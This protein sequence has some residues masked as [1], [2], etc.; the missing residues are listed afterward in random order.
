[1]LLF[2]GELGAAASLIQQLQPAIEATG[3]KRVPYSA[4]GLSAFAGRQAEAATQIDA[5]TTDVVLRGEGVGITI[6]EWASALLNNGIGNYEEAA[7]AAQSATEY[8]GEMITPPWPAVELIEAAVRCGRGDVAAEALR[9]LAEITTASGTDW[10]LGIEA[11]SRALLSDG[12]AAERWYR[13]AIERLG[14]TQIRADLARSHLLYGEWLRRERRRV[15][16]RTQLRIAHYML[17][18]MGMEAFAERARRELEATGET[19]RRRAVDS[20][21]EELTAQEGQIARMARDGLSNP[22][23]AARMFISARTVQ[24]HLSKVFTKLGITSRTQ[25]VGVLSN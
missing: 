13:E 7:S 3:S 15:D 22:E 18:A 21:D 11:R 5:I 4:L 19:A 2:A 25:L 16:A 14:R 12:D 17:D 20:R 6:V 23:I 9:R 1:M 8:L 10:A 24:Y